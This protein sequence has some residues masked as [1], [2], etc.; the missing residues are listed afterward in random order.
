MPMDETPPAD[1][2]SDAESAARAAQIERMMNMQHGAA[3]QAEQAQTEETPGGE[4]QVAEEELSE[5]ERLLQNRGMFDEWSQ[6][7]EAVHG[8]DAAPGGAYDRN[9][10]MLCGDGGGFCDEASGFGDTFELGTSVTDPNFCRAMVM[11]PKDPRQAFTADNTALVCCGANKIFRTKWASGLRP[12]PGWSSENVAPRPLRALLTEPQLAEASLGGDDLQPGDVIELYN[13]MKSPDFNGKQGQ[14]VAWVPDR[15]RYNVQLQGGRM[16]N[17]KPENVR[18]LVPSLV[19]HPITTA[20]SIVTCLKDIYHNHSTPERGDQGTPCASCRFRQLDFDLNITQDL[21][22]CIGVSS[23][24]PNSVPPAQR[25]YPG[26]FAENRRV[27]LCRFCA[28][29]MMGSVNFVMGAIKPCHVSGKP[30][31]RSCRQPEAQGMGQLRDGIGIACPFCS[32]NP[33]VDGSIR[34]A[35]DMLAN[36]VHQPQTYAETN[37]DNNCEITR[38]W[39]RDSSGN[40]VA[41]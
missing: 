3:P 7:D 9:P 4:A 5:M 18:H 41:A 25:E 37:I 1:G 22:S 14:V 26:E 2:A 11:Q 24:S 6:Y 12:P 40:V 21:N 19:G 30:H 16:L 28:A 15:E 10:Y 34:M 23:L 38:V 13:L 35:Q 31:A 27:N 32:F 33:S 20:E 8:A 29:V 36:Q 17:A 39:T